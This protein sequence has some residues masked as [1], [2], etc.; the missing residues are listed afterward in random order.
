MKA[1]VRVGGLYRCCLATIEALPDGGPW[2]EGSTLS[3]KHCHNPMRYTRGLF[4]DLAWERAPNKLETF[5]KEK[6]ENG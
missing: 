5:D 4:E 2:R 3:C 1:L 6:P